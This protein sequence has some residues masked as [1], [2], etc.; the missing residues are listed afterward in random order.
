MV[1]ATIIFLIM[2][3]IV[4]GDGALAMRFTCVWSLVVMGLVY[5]A[6]TVLTR[7]HAAE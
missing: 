6:I 2:S 1:P 3:L 5:V 4:H 7:R